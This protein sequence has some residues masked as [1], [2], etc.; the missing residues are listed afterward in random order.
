MP[1]VIPG[2][3]REH[4]G[5]SD[6]ELL[7]EIACRLYDAQLI[8]KGVCTRLT[9]M[10]HDEFNEQLAL[11]NLPIIRLDDDDIRQEFESLG[12]WERSQKAPHL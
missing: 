8:P 9:G 6:R 11:R 2:E 1:V 7:I 10:T 3:V 5:L 4:T 12:L